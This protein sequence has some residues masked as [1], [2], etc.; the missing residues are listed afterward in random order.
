MRLLSLAVVATLFA[1]GFGIAQEKKADKKAAKVTGA[2]TKVEGDKLTVTLKGDGG[3]KTEV[4]TT[5][6]KTKIFQQEA[7]APAKE[8]EKK[9][10]PKRTEI[11]LADLKTGSRVSVMAGEDKVATEVVALPAAKKKNDK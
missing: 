1:A 2:L 7:A 6:D 3:E 10:A 4:Y 11:K 5:N 8:G 9:P